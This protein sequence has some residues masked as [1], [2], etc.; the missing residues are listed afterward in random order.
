MPMNDELVSMA[1]KDGLIL[2]LFKK[3]MQIWKGY[4][5]SEQGSFG[6]YKTL[7]VGVVHPELILSLPNDLAFFTS[8]GARSLSRIL[9]TE[10]LDVTDFARDIDPSILA[11]IEHIK[12]NPDAKV[13]RFTYEKE[14]WYAFKLG[15]DVFVFQTNGSSYGWSKFTGL[16][17]ES[18]AFLNTRDAGLYIA[19]GRCLY[20][21]APN[22]YSDDDV[23]IKT[24]WWTPWLRISTNNKRWA[25]KYVSVITEQGVYMPIEVKRYK[26]Y[27]S[28]SYHKLETAQMSSPSYMDTAYWD[29]NT[30][31]GFNAQ[32][33]KKEDKFICQI[34]SYAVETESIKGPFKVHGLTIQGIIER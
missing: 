34:F 7:P 27:D 11:A 16:F 1:E 14:G 18:T 31:Q 33:A 21:Y 5:P 6:W 22:T 24:K 8:S 20:Q 30:W 28:F 10:Q 4:N 23:P 12:Q 9:Q 15:Q 26:D 32:A 3:N 13:G 2:F 25:N 29:T 19:K 17:A